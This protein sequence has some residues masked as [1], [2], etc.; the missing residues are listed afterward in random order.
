VHRSSR[1]S[2]TR[3]FLRRVGVY[4][5]KLAP[6]STLLPP[7]RPRAPLGPVPSNLISSAETRRLLP[8]PPQ[9]SHVEMLAREEG[10][11]HILSMQEEHNVRAWNIDPKAIE[12]ACAESSITFIRVPTRDHS[13]SIQQQGWHRHE[14]EMCSRARIP[15]AVRE[16]AR[17]LKDGGRVYVHCTAGMGRAPSAAI[18]FLFWVRGMDLDEAREYVAMHRP[19]ATPDRDAVRGA[20]Y[21]MLDPDNQVSHHRWL[22]PHEDTFVHKPEDAWASLSRN[23]RQELCRRLGIHDVLDFYEGLAATSGGSLITEK[24]LN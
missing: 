24:A 11:T 8:L 1:P 12:D 10:V 15:L 14:R 16:I 21:N 13:L 9:K 19:G 20:T 22:D 23:D 5:F 2:L 18:A 3:P 17:A 4:F 6:K 7:R